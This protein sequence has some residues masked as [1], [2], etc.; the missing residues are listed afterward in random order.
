VQ[1]ARFGTRAPP[2]ITEIL[3]LNVMRRVGVE[4]RRLHATDSSGCC[5]CRDRH[6]VGVYRAKYGKRRTV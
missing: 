2:D 6:F 3:R 1:I 5:I 4:L